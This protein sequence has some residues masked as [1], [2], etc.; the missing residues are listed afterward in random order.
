MYHISLNWL[1]FVN[2]RMFPNSPLKLTVWKIIWK[3]KLLSRV[4]LFATPWLYSPWN[5]PGQNT[6][7]NSLS[8]LQGIFPTQGSVSHIAGRFCTWFLGTQHWTRPPKAPHFPKA[9]AGG[10]QGS[11]TGA[12]GVCR[13]PLPPSAASAQTSER[14]EPASSC[15]T[16][17][18]NTTVN[19]THG[20]H[21][22][23]GHS[24]RTMYIKD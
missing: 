3:W 12:V 16:R 23:T 6:G 15:P 18:S 9:G 8:L 10:A 5:S 19:S 2:F 1:F 13:V 14:E 11:R 24:K 17:I 4:Q 21:G 20:W 22:N 7:V